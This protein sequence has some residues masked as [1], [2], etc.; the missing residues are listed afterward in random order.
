[1]SNQIPEH[2]LRQAAGWHARLSAP[3]CHPRDRHEFERWRA[4]HAANALAFD[5]VVSTSERIARLTQHDPR[6]VAMAEAALEDSAPVVSSSKRGKIA[7][8]AAAS[9]VLA[10][11]ALRFAP[12]LV[13]P[14]AGAVY[15]TAAGETQ[16]LQLTDGSTVHLDTASEI[17]VSIDSDE[18]RVTLTSGRAYFKVAKDARRPFS[19]TADDVRTTA[20]G[21]EFEVQREAG[22]VIVTLAEGVVE[23]EGTTRESWGEILAPGDEMR[24]SGAQRSR[25][26]IDLAY[27]ADWS[28]GRHEFQHT[29][30]AQAVTEINRY[31]RVKVRIGDPS[32]AQLA[33][34]GNFLIGDSERIVS[35]ITAALPVRAV[36]A[37]SQEIIL[38]PRYSAAAH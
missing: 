10:V 7:L 16:T 37:G 1:M 31:S 30:L 14:L 22:E 26:R 2:T 28:R 23:V 8:G 13:D 35:A 34:G 15:T 12:E 32:I 24:V 38:F 4:S 6:L 25:S 18:R 3:D 20:L 9:I 21:T 36:A 33:I 27:V 29:P 11:G 5:H 19:V 17:N